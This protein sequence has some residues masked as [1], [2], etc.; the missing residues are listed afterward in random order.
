MFELKLDGNGIRVERRVDAAT[1]W[2][3]LAALMEADGAAAASPSVPAMAAPQT[4]AP[5]AAR[6]PP[7]NGQPA[8]PGQSVHSLREFLDAHEPGRNVETIVAIATYLKAHRG[9]D[10]FTKEDVRKGFREASE[11][12]P[13]NYGRDFNWARSAGWIANTDTRG[14]YYVTE[15]G[16][17]AVE[18]NFPPEVKKASGVA[19]TARKRRPKAKTEDADE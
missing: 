8:S 3:V 16:R 7:A 18:A 2:R 4:A 14:G 11:P 10:T 5:A 13:G 1:A 17:K 15:T 12:V 19:R 9:M 6:Q